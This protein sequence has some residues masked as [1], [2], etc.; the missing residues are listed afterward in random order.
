MTDLWR[1]DDVLREARVYPGEQVLIGRNSYDRLPHVYRNDY[2]G[3]L[4]IVSHI[5]EGMAMITPKDA[6][7]ALA[8]YEDEYLTEEDITHG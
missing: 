7:W 6:K 3:T 1:E 2:E 4:G 5:E 8:F